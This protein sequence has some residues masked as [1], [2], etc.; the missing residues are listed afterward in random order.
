MVTLAIRCL[1]LIPF[2]ILILLPLELPPQ[3]S[4]G[5]SLGATVSNARI[6]AILQTGVRCTPVVAFDVEMYDTQL[7]GARHSGAS[8]VVFPLIQQ[9]TARMPH[10]FAH[11]VEI[12]ITIQKFVPISRHFVSV[13][14]IALILQIAAFVRHVAVSSACNLATLLTDARTALASASAVATLHILQTRVPSILDISASNVASHLILLPV[15]RITLVTATA[16]GTVC[17]LLTSARGLLD[18]ATSVEAP[19]ILQIA[20]LINVADASDV[21]IPPTLHPSVPSR[22][23]SDGCDSTG[24]RLQPPA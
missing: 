19:V 24:E 17:I 15:A 14:A 2:P 10:L 23:S 7:I 11:G 6:Q 9:A 12:P 22:S 13:V 16:V 1:I 8:A 5:L 18:S 20:A 4:L 21:A 3:I